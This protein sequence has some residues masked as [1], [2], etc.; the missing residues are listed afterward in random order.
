MTTF[1]VLGGTGIALVVLSLI[2]GDVLEGGLDGPLVG[3]RGDVAL[4]AG[5]VELGATSARLRIFPRRMLDNHLGRRIDRDQDNYMLD[6]RGAIAHDVPV[7]K[8]SS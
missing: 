3:G 4:S 6:E 7:T 2:L 1:L 5:R 8:R